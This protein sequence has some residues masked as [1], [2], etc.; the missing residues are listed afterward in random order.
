M[1]IRRTPRGGPSP[2][3]VAK[4]SDGARV[5]TPAPSKA[6]KDMAEQMRAV[7][8][9]ANRPAGGRLLQEQLNA[10]FFAE[11]LAEL[12]KVHWP[13]PE[14][15]RNLTVLVIAVSIVVGLFLGGVDFVF[16]KFFEFI[17]RLI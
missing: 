2:R 13:T 12:R 11:A 4:E 15:A 10:N 17:F 1:A 14:Q 8:S 16:Q 7:S 3:S 6:A 9:G 5:V